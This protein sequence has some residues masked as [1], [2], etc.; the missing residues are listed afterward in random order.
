MTLKFYRTAQCEGLVGGFSPYVAKVDVWL[1]MAGIPYE[2][3]VM[4]A[5]EAIES[6]PRKLSPYIDLDDERIGDSSIIIDRLSALHNDPLNDA[7]LSE[8]QVVLGE[9]VKSMC[10]YDLFYIMAYGRYGDDNTDFESLCKFNIGCPP[11]QNADE[12]V[13]Q[14]RQF[15]QDKLDAWRIGRYSAE[16]VTQ[17]LRRCL[18]VLSKALGAKPYLLDEKPSVYDASLFGEL[19]QLIYFPYRNSQVAVSREY[20][21]LVDYC[22]R[23]RAEF[24]DYP[25]QDG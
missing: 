5:A 17:E 20:T 25:P 8:E 22:D 24:Y 18:S 10:E 7:R 16:Y 23:L 1:R 19:T 13:A 15:V 3:I 11:D 12:A 9:L 4:V 2:E 6:G 14:F 21:N